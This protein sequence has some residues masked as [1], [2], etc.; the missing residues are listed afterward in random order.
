[1]FFGPVMKPPKCLV[2]SGGNT[3]GAFQ[4]GALQVYH[5]YYGTPECVIGTSIG[6]INGCLLNYIGPVALLDYWE[7]VQNKSDFLTYNYRPLLKGKIPGGLYHMDKVKTL[8]SDVANENPTLQS[9]A[10]VVNLTT[11]GIEYYNNDNPEYVDMVVASAS[12]PLGMENIGPYLDGGIRCQVP[13]QKALDLGYKPED[14]CVILTNPPWSNPDPGSYG[15]IHKNVFR[16]IDIMI[17]DVFW[18]DISPHLNTEMTFIAP[19]HRLYAPFNF[20]NKD[21][22]EAIDHGMEAAEK[23]LGVKNNDDE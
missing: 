11:G 21:I 18:N 19:D 4:A 1:M 5:K 20:S 17:H 9:W 16:S 23:V 14:I 13:I 12:E 6:S 15:G 10:T 7:S 8:I 22:R 3:K 2:L